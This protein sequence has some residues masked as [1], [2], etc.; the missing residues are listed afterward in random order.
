MSKSVYDFCLL[1]LNYSK[2]LKYSIGL[3]ISSKKVDGCLSVIDT[4]QK[5]IVKSSITISNNTNGFKI[6]ENWIV[7]HQKQVD[8]PL[9]ICMEATGIYYTNPVLYIY[10]KRSIKYLLFCQTKQRSICK[11]LV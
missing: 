5:V 2:M 9:V 10:L 6:L 8:I 4:T 1:N 11:Q 3:D 7:K